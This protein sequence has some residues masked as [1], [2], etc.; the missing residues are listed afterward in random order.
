MPDTN[1]L[2]ALRQ[3]IAAHFNEEELRLLCAE[4]G[5][6]YDDLGGRGRAANILELIK[7]AERHNRLSDLMA[8][9]KAARPDVPDIIALTPPHHI[10]WG[11]NR[12][13]TGR[14]EHLAWLDEQL[15]Q[16][17]HEAAAAAVTGLGGVGKTQLALEQC[18]RHLGDFELVQWLRAD[19]ALTL[20]GEMAELAYRLGLARRSVTDQSLLRQRVL[21]W[22]HSS[23][24]RWLLV[25]DNA[26]NIEP[27]ELAP[28]L[29]KLGRGASLITSRNPNWQ[30]LAPTL[31]LDGFTEAEA[32]DFLGRRD[33]DADD[34]ARLAQLLGYLPLALEHARAYLETTGSAPAEYAA[35][36]E[37]ER[38]A[39]WAE[40][41]VPPD[42]EQR[43]I[44]TTWEMA[45]NQARQTPGAAALLNLCCFL[46]PEDIPLELIK[47]AAEAETGELK[48]LA[49]SQLKLN[50]AIAILRRYA[51]LTREGDALSLHPL[52][53]TVARDRMPPKTAHTWAEATVDLLK[54]A[55]PFDQYDLETWPASARLL[56]H[57]LAVI[58]A[59]DQQNLETTDAAFLNNEA[60]SYFYFVTADYTAIRP[61]LERA[62]AIDE[63][64]LGP[65]HPSVATDLNNLGMLL[66][67]TGDLAA[68][69]PYLE[70]ALAIDEKALGPDHPSVATD[71]N[72][73]GML[74]K[75][76]GDYDAARPYMERT[77]TIAE[78]ALGPDHPH[79]A[80]ANNNL[81]RL[82]QAT[83][84]L[85]AARPYM[86]RALAIFEASLGP[87]HPNTAAV[88]DNLDALLAEIE[89]AS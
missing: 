31:R 44:T 63:K 81:G 61:Y 35:L 56:P 46:A 32:L 67:D 14:A 26:D 62:L 37:T 20:A 3:Q 83:G 70:R 33:A 34:T 1:N 59:A 64:A 18:Y 7:W 36:F 57:L 53:Q 88:R 42:Y 71:L 4:L 77:L 47:T 73:L 72:N 78:K 27:A 28:W 45:F 25:F 38:Q 17:G 49:A 19:N 89:D 43:T 15:N 69:R 22:L 13:F 8:A 9:V 86:E 29:P 50:A 51:L 80:A 48:P 21:D 6:E 58:A 23:G 68:A 82:L 87:D 41:E 12:L 16:E 65:D 2:T 24:R 10:P 5:L 30:R 84:D 54:A 60:A 66:Q 79:V 52:V 40:A 55:W 76:T 74:L 85:A 11:R 39:L 75:D